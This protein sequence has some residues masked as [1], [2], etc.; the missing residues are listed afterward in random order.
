MSGE[1][2]W[3]WRE[4]LLVP[5]LW[6]LQYSSNLLR[7]IQTLM[8]IFPVGCPSCKLKKVQN[9]EYTI[10]ESSSKRNLDLTAPWDSIFLPGRKVNMSMVFRRPLMSM[11]SCPECRTENEIED[12]NEGSEIQCS[13]MDCKMWYQRVVKMDTPREEALTTTSKI[14]LGKRRRNATPVSSKEKAQTTSCRRRCSRS[15]GSYQR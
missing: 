11:S 5:E 8:V 13:N 12:G 9:V 6:V 1:V 3:T 4:V 15:R 10:Q 2:P 7:I 14:Q